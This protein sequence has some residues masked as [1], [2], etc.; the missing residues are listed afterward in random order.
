VRWG[1]REEFFFCFICSITVND[2]KIMKMWHFNSIYLRMCSF[3]RSI[4]HFHC[5]RSYKFQMDSASVLVWK[6]VCDLT[7]A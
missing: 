1:R 4:R 3:A 2:N 5:D 7:V 6:N